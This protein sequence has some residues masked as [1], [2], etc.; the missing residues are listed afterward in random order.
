MN[1]GLIGL[2]RKVFM[3]D[4]GSMTF[5]WLLIGASKTPGNPMIHPVLHYL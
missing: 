2:E 1:L 5:I 3:G 4:A